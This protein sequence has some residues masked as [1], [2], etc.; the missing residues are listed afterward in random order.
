MSK[1]V[2][3]QTSNRSAIQPKTELVALAD[4]KFAERR[5]RSH[6]G[7]KRKTLEN[8]LQMQ[9][10]LDPITINGSGVVIDGC[11]RVEIARKLGWRTISAVRIEHLS[12]E[13]LRLHAIAANRLPGL[14]SVD[15]E[16][17]RLEFEEIQA[18]LP[19]LDLTMTGYSFGEIDRLRGHHAAGLYDDLDRDEA[20]D[21][22]APPVS[23]VGDTFELGDHRLVCGN[24]LEIESLDRLMDGAEARLIFTDPPY[25]VRVKGHVTSSEAH[26]EF[27][28]AS[29]EMTEVAFLQF[30]SSALSIGAKHLL[31]GGLA[32]VCMDHAHLDELL[33]AGKEVFDQRLNICVWDKGRGGMG[34]LYRSRHELVAVFKKGDAPH[35]N[36]V[37]LGKNGRDRSNVWSFPGMGG[38]GK[39]RK[40]A[41]ALHPTVKPVALIGEAILD[42]TAPGDMVLDMFGG[43]GSTLI[44]AERLNRRA[45]LIELS[46]TYVDRTITRWQDLTGRSA[47]EINMGLPFDKLAAQRAEEPL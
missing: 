28:M 44:A 41:R 2:A 21:E 6:P 11:L 4:L 40:K 34:S 26:P 27:A 16:A 45:R 24:S 36:N 32:Y 22:A 1:T 5:T 39:S 46:P 42:V 33:I 18:A 38:F 8:S 13:E 37:K 43:S 31:D 17:L 10:L 47:T 25:N 9:G 12:D 7:H 15:L 3:K 30:L 35:L 19:T 23:R 14:A 29:G 20:V